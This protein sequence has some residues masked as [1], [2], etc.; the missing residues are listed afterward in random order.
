MNEA[1]KFADFRRHT[2]QVVVVE[3]QCCQ[4][5]EAP[6]L[7][8]E[9]A[10]GSDDLQL[11]PVWF[12]ATHHLF[13]RHDAVLASVIMTMIVVIF[14]W[15]PGGFFCYKQGKTRDNVENSTII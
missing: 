4:E 14:F 1:V 11:F 12:L 15:H 3:I 5:V 10:Y 6:Q 2:H 9:I 8:A 7:R 13:W